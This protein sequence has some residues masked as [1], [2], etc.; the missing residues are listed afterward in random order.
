M[1][2]FLDL[3]AMDSR[4]HTKRVQGFAYIP[5]ALAL[6]IAG[7]PAHEVVTFEVDGKDSPARRLFGGGAVAVDM[8]LGEGTDAR[9]RIYLPVLNHRNQPIPW[10]ELTSRDIN[11]ATSRCIARAVAAV[12]G[13]GLSLYSMTDGDG[14]GYVDALGITPESDIAQA[15][16]I[17]DLKQIKDKRTGK[18][19]RSQEYL[20]WH[21]A[22]AACRITDPNFRWEVEEFT[23]IDPRTK[24]PVTAPMMAAPGKGWIVG[25]RTFYK[26][27]LH[28]MRLP[29]MGVETVETNN[30]D[31][32]ME[33]QP[34][35]TPTVF[36]WHSAIMRC[37]A[38]GI[39]ISTGYG[40]ACYA[41][42]HAAP[43]G[44]DAYED[45]SLLTERPE[46]E[47]A[48]D[49]PPQQ[50]NPSSG[51]AEQSAD[52]ADSEKRAKLLGRIEVEMKETSTEI[53]KFTSWLGV[54][55]LGT[56]NISVLERGLQALE[57]KRQKH[58]RNGAT[59]H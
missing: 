16:E 29:I 28:T 20:G 4:K 25:V 50:V 42:E 12:H 7:R 58:G 6:S 33:H 55:S 37:L 41:G 19:R 46:P 59:T 38:K 49:P 23:N 14:Q 17:R 3:L 5:W 43:G 13:Y 35:D 26:G 22:L 40:I 8:D 47:R 39:A 27:R 11:D 9:Q 24:G 21:S 57:A 36:S 2:T 45:E 51:N 15:V 53:G 44:Q 34:I 52:E 1:A 32:P 56:A 30:G 31:K 54:S 10:D 18:V 48:A